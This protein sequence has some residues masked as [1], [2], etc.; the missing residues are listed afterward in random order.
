MENFS[1]WSRKNL[2]FFPGVNLFQFLDNK[3]LDP[4][5]YSAYNAGSVSVSNEYGSQNLIKRFKP[6][7]RRWRQTEHENAYTI[8]QYQLLAGL[9]ICIT[10]LPI[11]IQLST[12]KRTRIRI[13]MFTLWIK[14]LL[15]IKAMGICDIEPSGLQASIVNVHGPSW[16]YFGPLNKFCILTLMQTRIQLPKETGSGSTATL[17]AG[18]RT[19]L[20]CVLTCIAAQQPAAARTIT[21]TTPA[22]PIQCRVVNPWIKKS[23]F[24]IFIRREWQ[25]LNL[26]FPPSSLPLSRPSV[27]SAES[28]STC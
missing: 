5:R 10:F 1:F 27:P 19:G 14:I 22:V 3:T 25:T 8:I 17:A 26:P 6:P 4:D 13:Q 9:R 21:V 15:L 7:T 20:L 12:S 16:F 2:I 24:I 11:R 28:S 23:M 18:L